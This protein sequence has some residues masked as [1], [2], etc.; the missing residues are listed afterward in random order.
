MY[1][2]VSYT[3]TVQV[4]RIDT[5]A[6]IQAFSAYIK[7][8]DTVAIILLDNF[9]ENIRNYFAYVHAVPPGLSLGWY[10]G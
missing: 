9:T 6:L 10:Q 2:C 7:A 5:V 8:N 1:R 3:R 4:V